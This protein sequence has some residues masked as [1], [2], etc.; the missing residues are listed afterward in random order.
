MITL[1]NISLEFLNQRLFK[2]FSETFSLNDRIGVV[3][4]N[5]AG[6]STLLKIIARLQKPDNGSVLLGKNKIAYLPQEVVVNS[7]QS[8]LDEAF[9]SFDS[10]RLFLEQQKLET[11]L[12][13]NPDDKNIA[14]KLVDVSHEL[15]EYNIANDLQQ[16]KNILMGL[17]F[18]EQQ[19]NKKVNELSVGW[20]MRLL[21]ARL[22]LQKADFYLF[23]EPTNHLDITTKDWFLNFLQNS[24]TGFLLISHERY[25][26]NRLCEK[27]LALENGNARTY[28]GNYDFFEKEKEQEIERLKK[29]LIVQNKEI[30]RKQETINRFRAT[31]SKVKMV[32]S[33]IK[34]LAKIEPI[35]LPP[36]IKTI[37]LP[38]S[39]IQ[40]SNRHVLNTKH[41]TFGYDANNPLFKN[42]NFDIE[43]G[44]KV[45]IVAP[46]GKG[47]TTL[48]KIIT[49]KLNPQNGSINFDEKTTYAIFEQD[50]YS[51]L[52]MSKNI[53]DEVSE[54]VNATYE[55]VRSFLGA[56]LFDSD[57]IQKKIKVL[58][59]GEKNRVKLVKALLK[60][61]N[62]LLLDEPTNHLDIASKD[63]L[64]KALQDFPGTILFVSHDR[65]FIN[66]VAT[67][68]IDLRENDTFMYTGNYDEF[69]DQTKKSDVSDVPM[70]GKSYKEP[71]KIDRNNRALAE[72][73]ESFDP[74]FAKASAD[75]LAFSPEQSRRVRTSARGEPVESIRARVQI[76]SQK[77]SI[78]NQLERKINRLEFTIKKLEEKFASLEYGTPEFDKALKQSQA[79]KDEL[80]ELIA[81]WEKYQAG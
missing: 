76:E 3:G 77:K 73:L 68:V 26:L 5:G 32:Q 8:V 39:E 67:H 19:L 53:F 57:S 62:L 38:F 79:Y 66:K 22:L 80:E 51:S 64:V 56:F 70:N 40:K 28:H 35:V 9:S 34:E 4:P 45:A 44:Q 10:G 13:D 2:D 78:V 16:T 47:K 36:Q 63:I 42:V 12:K 7:D 49:Q 60:K 72:S 23:D 33:M 74:A 69:L 65:D 58:S 37:K 59:G 14:T 17:G 18:S 81:E 6:K 48:F 43:R 21:L 31:P 30:S 41:L 55:T 46:N 15:A 54:S 1:K 50:E 20:K 29:A 27:T 52:N 75:G 24:E 61:T 71:Q 25:F 11:I